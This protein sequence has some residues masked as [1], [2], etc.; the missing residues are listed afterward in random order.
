MWFFGKSGEKK[1]KEKQTQKLQAKKNKM[2]VTLFLSLGFL[3]YFILIGWRIHMFA[4]KF[5]A[6]NG[7]WRIKFHVFVF[8]DSH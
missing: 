6:R 8:A 4:E 5:E 3:F 2:K 1:E 7:K